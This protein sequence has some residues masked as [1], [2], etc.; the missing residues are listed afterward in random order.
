MQFGLAFFTVVVIRSR[1]VVRD[2]D[3]EAVLPNLALIALDEK[4]IGVCLVVTALVLLETA[5][6][7]CNLVFGI[8]SLFHR[9]VDDTLSRV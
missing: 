2:S 8:A 3:A 7:A 4:A 1:L 9:F 5:D 6:A